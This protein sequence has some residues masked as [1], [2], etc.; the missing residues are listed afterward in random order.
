MIQGFRWCL[1]HRAAVDRR[2]TR[3]SLVGKPQAEWL[4]FAKDKCEA[5]VDDVIAPRFQ[6]A[7]VMLQSL[8]HIAI[9]F[10]RDLFAI[11]SWAV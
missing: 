2:R 11:F 10:D 1:I 7:A 6:A 4:V 9:Q 8:Q 3:D 5:L